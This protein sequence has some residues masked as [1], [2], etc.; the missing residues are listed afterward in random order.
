MVALLA[1]HLR[2]RQVRQLASG[3][4]VQSRTHIRHTSLHTVQLLLQWAP[5]GQC[6][7]GY[8][9]QGSDTARLAFLRVSKRRVPM[10]ELGRHHLAQTVQ[11]Q[12]CPC[13]FLYSKVGETRVRAAE[14]VAQLL[15][16]SLRLLSSNAWRHAR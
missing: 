3:T 8:L 14:L 2:V 4:H 7:I 6:G 10:V 11:L 16:L 12:V 15:D 5:R 9:H 13:H 1:M